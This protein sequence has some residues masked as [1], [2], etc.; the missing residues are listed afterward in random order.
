[1]AKDCLIHAAAG[2][3]LPRV[4]TLAELAVTAGKDQPAYPFFQFCKALAEYRQGH[5]A[6]A[7]EWARQASGTSFSLVVVEASAVLAMAQHQ[8]QQ[9]EAARTS[10]IQAESTFAS[11][12]PQLESGDIGGDWRDWVIARA[13]LTEAQALIKPDRGPSTP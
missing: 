7:A 8:L 6:S 4:A 13:L 10:L 2:V 9:P 1:M 3:D 5:F 12:L 11:K